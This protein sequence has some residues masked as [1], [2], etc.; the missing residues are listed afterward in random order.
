MKINFDYKVHYPLGGASYVFEKDLIKY[1]AGRVKKN[2]IVI[3]IGAQP[4]SSPH[5]GTLCVFSLAFSLA[6]KLKEYNNK[7]DVSVLFE[8]VDTAPSKTVD[9]N[10]IKYQYDLRGTEK[11]HNSM[12]DFVSV[13]NY[14]SE[15]TNIKYVIRNQSEF[16]SQPEIYKVI[17]SILKNRKKIQSMLDPKNENLRIR[18]SCPKCGLVDKEGITTNITK[19][20]IIATCPNHGK[21]S[22]IYKKAS[23][24]LEYN[25]PLRNLIRGM[26]Y[27][28]INS[29]SNYDYEI[30]RITGADY[31]GFYQEELL[32]KCASLC[33]YDVSKLPIIL[34]CPQILD[35]SGAK[36]S[37]SLYV[38]E[39][40]YKDLPS[41]M[42]NYQEMYDC[43][44]NKGLDIISEETDKW[45]DE[46]YKLF[47]NYTVYYFIKKFEE[48]IEIN[49]R[50][51]KNTKRDN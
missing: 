17:S 50:F 5:F 4:N 23:K 40:V 42:L 51:K 15:K 36:L 32:Y 30:I 48:E 9:I 10:G 46:S 37:K 2:K 44:E 20:E 14:F 27:G 31:S 21:Y 33:N 39:G 38:Q 26:V 18:T 16:N 7:I 47:R 12:K 6:K 1:I 8:V 11:M 43:F 13:L 49:D 45:L 41:Y 22:V 34:Y 19:K 28:L 24:K 25:T 3:S 29:S 35:W